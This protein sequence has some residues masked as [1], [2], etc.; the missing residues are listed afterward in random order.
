[1]DVT[2]HSVSQE[3]NSDQNQEYGKKTELNMCVFP[4]IY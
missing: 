1:M 2:L 4:V 3:L